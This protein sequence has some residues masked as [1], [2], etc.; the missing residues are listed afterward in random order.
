M[1]KVKR[2][3]M[4]SVQYERPERRLFQRLWS[5]RPPIRLGA[6]N[7]FGSVPID[8]GTANN[9]KVFPSALA[10]TGYKAIASARQQSFESSTDLGLP[11]S[12]PKIRLQ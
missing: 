5:A 8:L 6:L 3:R 11:Y 4:T 9:S 1:G 2:E 12:A 10:L 7:L